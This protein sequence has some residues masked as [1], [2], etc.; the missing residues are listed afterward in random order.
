VLSNSLLHHLRDPLVL[1]SAVRRHGA[2]GAPVFIMD[3]KRPADSAEAGRLVDAYAAGEPEVL[4][5]DFYRSLLAAFEIEEIR[6]Q[7]GVAGLADFLSVRAV[8]DRHVAAWGF[9][10]PRP[11]R[12]KTATRSAVSTR[13]GLGR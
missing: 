9:L 12:R 11:W 4:R 3:L 6:H 7:L 13:E 2:P 1:W 10:P 5:H 8:S